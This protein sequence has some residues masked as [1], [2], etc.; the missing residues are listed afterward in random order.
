MEVDS[1]HDNNGHDTNIPYSY[2]YNERQDNDV[3]IIRV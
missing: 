3:S 1:I 2:E